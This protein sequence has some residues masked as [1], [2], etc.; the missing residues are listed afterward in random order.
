MLES[1]SVQLFDVRSPEEF[2]AGRIPGSTNIP[3]RELEEALKMPAVDFKALFKVQAPRKEDDNIV[4]QCQSGRRS[5]IALDT[6]VALGY[7]RAHHYAGGY[8]E[9]SQRQDN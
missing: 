4:F 9:W 6:A 3:L 5:L 2:Q 8:S 1:H 7:M